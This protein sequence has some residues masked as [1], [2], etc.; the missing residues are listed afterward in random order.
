VV[1]DFWLGVSIGAVGMLAL[2]TVFWWSILQTVAKHT[3]WMKD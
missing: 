1:N 3:K 2:S